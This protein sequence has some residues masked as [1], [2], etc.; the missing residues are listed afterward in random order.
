MQDSFV[1]FSKA[2]ILK[3]ALAQNLSK[4]QPTMRKTLIALLICLHS[5]GL[6][7]QSFSYFIT[8]SIQ[9]YIENEVLPNAWAGGLN[10]TS[11]N[12]LD[13]NEDGEE[14]LVLYDRTNDKISVFINRDNRWEYTPYFE[15]GFPQV[16][17]WLLLRDYNAD[18]LKDLF[19]GTSAGIKIYKNLGFENG[20]PIWELITDLIRT[21]GF[22]GSNINLKVD[23]TDVPGIV[24]V[25]NDGDLD[26]FTV[27]PSIGGSVE[28]H[29]N[30]GIENFNSPDSLIFEKVTDQW[31]SLVE[32]G[33]C[34][35][36]FF[37]G[38]ASCRSKAV[39]H[40]GSTILLFDADGDGDKELIWGESD[41]THLT[42]FENKGSAEQ[43][44]FDSFEFNFP[45][46]E[47]A[48]ILFPAA[49]LEDVDFD[50]TADIILTPNLFAN[51]AKTEDFANSIRRYKL[52]D[53][54]GDY[55][56]IE[57]NFLQNTMIE[58]GE[59][60]YPA[61]ADEDG[62]GDLDL[63]IANKGRPTTNT[64]V[65]SILLFENQGNND[66]P[67]FRLKTD[68]Y[69]NLS[70]FAYQELKVQFVDINSDGK[71]DLV[72]TA[73]QPGTSP[74]IRFLLNLAESADAQ[75]SYSTSQIKRLNISID[76]LDEAHFVDVDK[77]GNLDLLLGKF[78]GGELLYFRNTGGTD[79]ESFSF[80]ES[81]NGFG[82]ITFNNLKRELSL[83][84]A[85]L[86]GNGKLDL[87]TGDR[88][89]N[90]TFYPD[91]QD[92]LTADFNTIGD[93]IFNPS[94]KQYVQYHFGSG[95][96]PVVFNKDII[97]G[98]ETGGLMFL[99]HNQ[100]EIV[101]AL[102]K[103][104]KAPELSVYPNPVADYLY[105]DV[106]LRGTLEIFDTQGVKVGS[107]V[108]NSVNNAL[109]V[110]MPNAFPNGLYILRFN[111]VNGVMRKKITLLR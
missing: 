70:K 3:F 44:L 102:P 83:E 30:L 101:S 74:A 16:D 51:E 2:Q 59:G 73:F 47:S 90:I 67:L 94:S 42:Y 21:Q 65:A 17:Y 77:D 107:F 18:G 12:T 35:D 50:N 91:F 31:G 34:T 46:N 106:P 24:D 95:V 27:L 41:C 81:V 48:N 32:C 53:V 87:L 68:D 33:N 100:E 52:D 14:D 93:T 9:V 29:R 89:G 99:R 11:V 75:L 69:L 88:S 40:A 63:F 76:R 64:F 58:V 71:Q 10:S 96:F 28:F 20:Q 97:V 84:T 26:I 38:G 103:Q 43:V 25:D 45:A 85:D 15:V 56:L 105:L 61:V 8:D 36:Y 4:Q 1:S 108:K 57:N 62:D 92:D 109:K 86:D 37:D 39:K 6:Y 19:T 80:E 60:A 5:I 55:Q 54:S 23:I 111:S 22:S 7:A 78:R 72:Y 82:G 104:T 110:E 79:P 49:F 66:K 98:L 13:V